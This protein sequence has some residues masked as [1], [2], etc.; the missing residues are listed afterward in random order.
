MSGV[1]AAAFPFA[2]VDVL[3][4]TPFLGNPLAVVFDADSLPEEAMQRIARWTN[5]SET[6]FL[7][8]ADEPGA[9]YRVRIFTPEEEL[10][11]AGHPTLGSAHAWLEW[12]G[13]QRD[14]VAQQ[15][16]VGTVRVRRAGRTLSF[17]SPPLLRSGPV[18]E[19]LL[20][21]VLALLGVDPAHVVDAQWTDNGGGWLAVRL[22][23]DD[24]VLALEPDFRAFTG[25]GLL[26]V[27]VVGAC[28]APSEFAYEV[29]AFYG[30][31]APGTKE[32]P[33]TGGLNAAVAQWL[34]ETGAFEPPYVVSQ[35]T[36]LGR[37]GRVHVDRD[38]SGRVWIGGGVR[39]L[40]TGTI[41]A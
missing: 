24:S 5:Q 1:T 16:A 40:V 25:D 13:T 14:A 35:G 26:K 38:A 39:T 34:C 12:T 17:E 41:D 8:T 18:D 4:R 23:D 19:P 21:Q 9:D 27:G 11:F 30:D 20:A 15:C 32:D 29:R 10:A 22:L 2:M 33:V 37:A 36:R 7:L 28:R 3:S 6:V 31:R